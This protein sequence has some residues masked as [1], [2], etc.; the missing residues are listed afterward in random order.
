[1]FVLEQDHPSAAQRNGKDHQGTGK[2]GTDDCG[3]GPRNE[4]RAPN[5]QPIAVWL[6]LRHG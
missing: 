4:S 1:M 3:N 6:F 5:L 2:S